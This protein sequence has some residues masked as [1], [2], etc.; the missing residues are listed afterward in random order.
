ML[1]IVSAFPGL[2]LVLLLWH[3]LLWIQA[4]IQYISVKRIFVEK[5]KNVVDI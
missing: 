1:K 4:F 2:S 3:M 5:N